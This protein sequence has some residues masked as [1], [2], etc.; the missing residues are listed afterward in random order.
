MLDTVLSYIDEPKCSFKERFV[1][2]ICRLQDQAINNEPISLEEYQKDIDKIL[3]S[4][5]KGR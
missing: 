3:E 2:Y 1:S 5:P 4:L